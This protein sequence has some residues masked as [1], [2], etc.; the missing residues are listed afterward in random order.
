[1]NEVYIIDAA[2]TAVGN[3]GGKLSSLT[4]TQLGTT[5][6][7]ALLDRN[8]LKGD[9]IDEVLMGSVLQAG[10][11]QNVA[12]QIQINSGIPVDKTAMTINMV[13]GS[14]L[15]TVTLASQSIKAGDASIIIAGGKEVGLLPPV[16][17]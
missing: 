6:I 7:K 13:C 2:R 9:E 1:M 16:A 11:G 5:V 12:R 15:R 17:V 14:G 4:A 8:G 3:F 10:Q